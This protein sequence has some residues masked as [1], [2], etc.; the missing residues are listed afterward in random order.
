MDPA[1]RLR[2]RDRDAQELRYLQWPAKQ[3]IERRAAGILKHQR[4]A[5][6]VARQRDRSCRPARVKFGFERGFVFKSL[7]ATERGFF[8]GNKQ[9][10]R[11]AVAGATV[12]SD[13]SLPQRR[14]HVLRE[15]H[16]QDPCE[17]DT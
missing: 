4:H 17:E 2:E 6:V 11:Q 9:D 8:R 14:E 12:E 16:H 15:L 3:P 13:V 5:L 1:E 10:R 7:D